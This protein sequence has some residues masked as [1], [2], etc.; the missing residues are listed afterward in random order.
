MTDMDVINIRV[1]SQ[2]ASFI[3]LKESYM[4]ARDT[5]NLETAGELGR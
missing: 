2:N 5:T 3:L 1:A 4:M